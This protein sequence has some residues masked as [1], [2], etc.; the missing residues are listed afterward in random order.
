M[1]DITLVEKLMKEEFKSDT[2]NDSQK[3]VIYKKK[4][5]FHD[6]LASL[7]SVKYHSLAIRQPLIYLPDK[8]CGKV[9]ARRL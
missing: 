4:W 6:M 5:R 2:D 1:L 7:E 9:N 3:R 8:I